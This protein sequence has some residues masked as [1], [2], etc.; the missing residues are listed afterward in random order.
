MSYIDAIIAGIVQ[1]ISEFLPISS[2]GHLV[3]LKYF[4][5]INN[6]NL[7]YILFLHFGTLLALLLV[8]RKDIIALCSGFF[9]REKDAINIVKMILITII[10]AG[11]VGMFF[12]DIVDKIFCSEGIMM[13]YHGHQIPI[14]PYKFV[15]LAF[16]LTAQF[17]IMPASKKIAELKEKN[18]TGKNMQQLNWIS[19]LTIG[20]FQ[21]IAV[22]P[23]VSR[24]GITIFAGLKMGLSREATAKFS[25]LISIPIILGA[26]L[27]D[28]L[29]PTFRAALVYEDSGSIWIMLMGI[30]IAAITGYFALKLIMRC[31]MKYDL[32]VFNAYLWI[33]GL[34]SIAQ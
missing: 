31:I 32:K 4:I 1:G 17:V 24:S 18:I 25:F 27:K 13:N 3:V 12:S 10:P 15:G 19:A 2:S 29:D 34:I 22:I 26:I 21:A 9:K 14:E 33:I 20:I 16:I 30:A 8:F 6:L 23:G 11:F 7:S 5:P 28:F